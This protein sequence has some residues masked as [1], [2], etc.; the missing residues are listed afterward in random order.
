MT[1][2]KRKRLTCIPAARVYQA[3][4]RSRSTNSLQRSMDD[5]TSQL[6]R[7]T[8]NSSAQEG[9]VT[10][11]AA[12]V[13]Q[14][15]QPVRLLDLPAEMRIRVYREIQVEDLRV[16]SKHRGTL[17]CTS[18]MVLINRQI[19]MEFIDELHR[20]APIHVVV[21]D[22]D[23]R[24]VVTALN[25][26]TPADLKSLHKF[27]KQVATPNPVAEADT[28]D[29]ADS[30]A[31][32]S[33]EQNGS[34][35]KVDDNRGLPNW[36]TFSIEMRIT[37]YPNTELFDCLSRWLNRFDSK[38]RKA[39]ADIDFTYSVIDSAASELG[40][41]KV[42]LALEYWEVELDDYKQSMDRGEGR[43]L[44]ELK[45]IKKAI[46]EYSDYCDEKLQ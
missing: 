22:F 8:V 16:S 29:K 21:V 24:H 27:T 45:K 1:V 15:N 40:R 20:T 17:T 23:F 41:Q 37:Q 4:R 19:G 13:L 10:R 46:T 34:A 2:K 9:R 26:L 42:T 39:G 35:T 44:L 5:V 18:N 32:E 28:E 25:R 33:S 11:S 6:S 30:D 36:R 12:R 43:G 38:A 3:Q 7:T 31:S 14:E